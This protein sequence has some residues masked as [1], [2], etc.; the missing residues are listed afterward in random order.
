[1]F[2]VMINIAIFALW[3]GIFAGPITLFGLR[4]YYVINEQ[5]SLK[6]RLFILFLPFSIGIESAMAKGKFKKLYDGLVI[7][8]FCLLLLGS[9]FLFAQYKSM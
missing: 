5:I 4:L 7:A 3:I 1:M 8:F 6:M 9:L 2:D